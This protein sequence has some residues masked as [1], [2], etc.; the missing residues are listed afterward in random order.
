MSARKP[1][2]VLRLVL[3]G[4]VL[5]TVFAG[6]SATAAD[7]PS[8][9]EIKAGLKR[10]HEK[11]RSLYVE[12]VGETT[13]PFGP[14][15]L[16]RLRSHYKHWVGRKVEYHYAFQG[17]KRYSREKKTM[18][19]YNGTSVWTRRDD[20]ETV[21]PDGSVEKERRIVIISSPTRNIRF[22]YPNEWFAIHLGA[23]IAGPELSAKD[24]MQ[25]VFYYGSPPPPARRT[26]TVSGQIDEVDGAKCAVVTGTI[27]NTYT[28]DNETHKR[29][30]YVKFWLDIERDL[31]LRK[32]EET[33]APGKEYPKRLH[34]IVNSRFNE[35]EPGL[36]LPQELEVQRIAPAGEEEYPE[37][38]RGKTILS[39]RIQV[40][41][42]IVNQVPDDVFD[43]YIKP[44]DDVRDSRGAAPP[45]SGRF[46]AGKDAEQITEGSGGRG[47]ATVGMRSAELLVSLSCRRSAILTGLSALLR[48]PVDT[49]A[50]LEQVDDYPLFVMTYH[51]TY[52][53]DWFASHGIDWA[54][55]RAIS[56]WVDPEACASFTARTSEGGAIFG[57]NFDWNNRA[58]LLL[59]TNPPGGYASVSMVDLYYLGFEGTQDTAL[60]SRLKLLAAP[61][62]TF[63]G[64]N[65]CGLAIASNVA[66]GGGKA[67]WDPEKPTL[68][69]NQ[70]MRLI[71]DHAKD[72]EEALS[73]LRKY[74]VNRSVPG[75]T[76][77]THFHI[78]DASGKSV[79]VEYVDGR[80]VVVS[81]GAAWQVSTNFLI[82]KAQP[83]GA[84]SH[85]PRYNTAYE[86]LGKA[87]G[88]LSQDEPMRLLKS[89]SQGH[90]M[91]SVVYNLST[92]EIRVAMGRNYER[93]HTLKLD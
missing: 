36:W 47:L 3:P 62:V 24:S 60:L 11:I 74:N 51:G 14:E 67:P 46:G 37:Q 33:S 92:G 38:F 49:L 73:L 41:K 9:E 71:L 93:L 48:G 17:E 50:S 12:T 44:G 53:L 25:D 52:F 82:S 42:W 7:V 23:A 45:Q 89:I 75:Y 20:G 84:A 26:L 43:P 65:E 55:Y 39:N 13:S 70:M 40:T 79:V 68:G 22:I 72:V 90:T 63:D 88:T 27:E 57:R 1:T 19:A 21:H 16:G 4:V 6:A 58:S 87:E 56:R 5:A 81:S 64:M 54:V 91:W 80:R 15:E 31:A 83:K 18:W 78:A 2:G 69:P 10:R 85:C 29:V 30:R 77:P 76:L 34:R 61:Y 32:W 35:V 66:P 28:R 86:S 8:L 59:F